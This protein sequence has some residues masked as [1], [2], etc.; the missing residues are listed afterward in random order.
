MNDKRRLLSVR[1]EQLLDAAAKHG[2]DA[3]IHHKLD[4]E[5][6]G[7]DIKLATLPSFLRGVNVGAFTIGG[8][9]VLIPEEFW[10][11]DLPVWARFV[12]GGVFLLGALNYLL[13]QRG[14]MVAKR[15]SRA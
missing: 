4:V 2:I 3:T 12:V 7:L 14:L 8:L 11:I 5:R 15:V 10:G 9:N 6:I 13:R 1:D